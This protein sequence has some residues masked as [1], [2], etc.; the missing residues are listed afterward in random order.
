MRRVHVMLTLTLENPRGTLV[1][2]RNP[3]HSTYP[4]LV[5]TLS[6]HRSPPMD[7]QS[8]LRASIISANLPAPSAQLLTL[9][10]TS[11]NPPPPLPSLLATAK[12]RLLSADLTSSPLIDASLGTLPPDIFNAS[13]KQAF[14]PRDVH[15]QVVDVE[16]LCLSR[17]EQID[18]LE[19]IE[20]GERTRGREVIRVDD[21]D[22]GNEPRTQTQRPQ[23]EGGTAGKNGTHRLVL[24]D[25]TGRQVF[26]VELERLHRVGIG[27]TLMGEKLLI[28]KGLVV[29]RG[30][31]LLTG[32]K[33]VFLGGKVEAWHKAWTEGRLTRLKES[34]ANGEQQ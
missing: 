4:G 12:A 28:K 23:G 21:E 20:R 15:V 10:T 1:L 3:S 32:D 6:H 8:Q 18:E 26:A 34:V 31:L 16:N 2:H 14:L 11:R 24:Q 17:W 29:A 13:T 25:R 7:L 9:L 22:E 19:S 5:P 33:V 27:K 30:S